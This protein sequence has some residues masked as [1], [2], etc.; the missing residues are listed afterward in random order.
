MGFRGYR[1]P[2]ADKKD[3][4]QEIMTQLWQAVS[5]SSFDAGEQFWGFVE[6]V[7]ARRCIDWARG[8]YVKGREVELDESQPAIGPG[9][10]GTT[11]AQERLELAHAAL[12]QLAKPCRDLIYLHVGLGKSYSELAEQFNKS[13]GALRVQMHRCIARAR[14]LLK[15]GEGA[16]ASR[17]GAAR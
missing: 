3:L 14:Q 10:L 1:M 6:V 9:P 7:T 17:K 12:A 2:A 4:E 15:P 8:R 11:L 5:R 16:E 13:E